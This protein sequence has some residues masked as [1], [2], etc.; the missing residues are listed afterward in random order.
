VNRVAVEAGY[1]YPHDRAKPGWRITPEGREFAASGGAAVTEPV[2]NVDTGAE[3]ALPP[4]AAQGAAFEKW[5]LGFLRVSYPY[6]AWYH[7]G[8][9]K[10]NERGLDFVGT[11]LG[12][13]NDEPR[14]IGVQVKLH[15]AN[16]APAQTEWLKFLAGCFA[17]RVNA[18]VFVTTGR[19]TGEQRRES[20]EADVTVLEGAEEIARM[21]QLHGLEPFELM[22]GEHEAEVG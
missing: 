9:H 15:K 12:D 17:R 1:L 21:A 6:Y 20:Q 8:V 2:M 18:A 16:N 5:V 14:S 22:R 7:Q 10:H 19:L 3:V 11:R 13:A 4:N